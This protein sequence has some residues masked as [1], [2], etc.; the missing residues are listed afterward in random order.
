[1]RQKVVGGIDTNRINALTKEKSNDSRKQNILNILIHVGSIF[2]GTYFHHRHVPKTTISERSIVEKNKL[3]KE[4]I[5]EIKKGTE[6]E[7]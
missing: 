7:Q 4:R 2:T 6:H 1:M 3:R 5:S